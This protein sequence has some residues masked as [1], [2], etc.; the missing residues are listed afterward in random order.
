MSVLLRFLATGDIQAHEWKQFATVT[1]E[2]M[3]SRLHNI[4]S[5]FDVISREAKSRGIKKL[6]IN[7]DVFE[8]NSYIST[9]T[10]DGVY[11]KLE[12]LHDEGVE[13]V[14]NLGNHDVVLYSASRV[15]HALRPFRKV[16]TIFERPGVAWS[17]VFLVPYEPD[18][19]KIKSSFAALGDGS[20]TCVAAHVG[21]QGGSVGPKDYL[22]RCPIKLRDLHPKRIKLILLSDFHKSQFLRKNVLYMGSPIQHTF[23]EV[24]RP[25]IWDVSLL[26]E[27][28]WFKLRRIYTE[29]PTFRRIEVDEGKLLELKEKVRGK[30]FPLHNS[31]VRAIIT[32]DKVR[33]EDLEELAR[34]GKFL[35]QIHRKGQTDAGER[36]EIEALD[37]RSLIGKYVHE[38]ARGKVERKRLA[39]LGR[40]LY[41]GG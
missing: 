31:Y 29:F 24:H 25:K 35:L 30:D 21:V 5:V 18:V 17:H 27:P 39:N 36:S 33:D 16:A 10:Y 6:L 15:L 40:E 9:E 23:G 8:E 41:P 2:G 19:E 1:P 38:N 14:I 32:S 3:N 26:D 13:T 34:V 37:A 28:P 7:G 11:R 4:L 20:C 22:L 12:K